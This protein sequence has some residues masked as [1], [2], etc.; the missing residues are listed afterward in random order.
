MSDIKPELNGALEAFA[1]GGSLI[2]RPSIAP[3]LTTSG[4]A[5]AAKDRRFVAGLNILIQSARSSHRSSVDALSVA[6][7]LTSV[8]SMREHRRALIEGIS[9]GVPEFA[10]LPTSMSDPDDRRHFADAMFH[11]GGAW[12]ASYLARAIVAERDG[13]K[14]REA[15]CRAFVHDVPSVAAQIKLIHEALSGLKFEQLDPGAGKARRATAVL[16]ALGAAHWTADAEVTPGEE[17]G[18]ALAGIATDI[19]L[20]RA[21]ANRGVLNLFGA[22]LLNF[23]VIVIR[24]HGSLAADAATYAFVNPMRRAFG[25]TQWPTAV[26]QVAFKAAGQVLDQL[27]LLVRL[28]MPDAE[29][30]RVFVQLLGEGD[31][32]RRINLAVEK[33]SNLTPD[34]AHWLQTGAARRTLATQAAIAETA[35]SAVDLDLAL[36]LRE[37][38]QLQG[39]LGQLMPE[40]RALAEFHSAALA[41]NISVLED[42]IERLSSAVRRA[43]QKRGLALVGSPGDV[44]EFSP[45]EHEPTQDAVGART[46]RVLSR[47]VERTVDGKPVGYVLRADVTRA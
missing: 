19:L 28:G 5:V 4:A 21:P 20:R 35:V 1:A 3:L 34:G 45:L 25:S 42:R 29:L 17:L 9:E 33:E 12:K 11:V 18:A 8:T 46:V 31:A 24:L 44:V 23:V 40:L 6:W 26:E 38:D 22:S 14:A 36:G 16:D 13:E 32:R 2:D 47:A 27:M 39:S 43:A 37:S 15:L 41:A 30:R 10:E 7:R